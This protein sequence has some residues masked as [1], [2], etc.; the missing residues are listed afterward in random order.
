[1]QLLEFSILNTLKFT[2]TDKIKVAIMIG[3]AVGLSN[4]DLNSS[5][6]ELL[7]NVSASKVKLSRL[8]PDGWK[9]VGRLFNKATE[10]G[11]KWNKDLFAKQTQ[12][13][14]ELV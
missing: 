11:I 12:K 1:M 5:S 6:P 3:T 2:A 13:F 10:M 9:I 14:M 7:V 4:S 8:T